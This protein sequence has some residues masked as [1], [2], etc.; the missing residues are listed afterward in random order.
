MFVVEHG[1]LYPSFSVC[2]QQYYKSQAKKVSGAGITRE[3]PPAQWRRPWCMVLQ[4]DRSG[5]DVFH[6]LWAQGSDFGIAVVSKGKDSR[7]NIKRW[8]AVSGGL[9]QSSGK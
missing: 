5:P 3:E 9:M 4:I 6:V 2:V 8:A 1:E 7:S